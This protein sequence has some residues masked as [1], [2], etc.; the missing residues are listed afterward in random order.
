MKKIVL[1]RNQMHYW[2]HEP[3]LYYYERAD[4]L[5]L[6]T[7]DPITNM[8]YLYTFPDYNV[9]RIKFLGKIYDFVVWGASYSMDTFYYLSNNLVP[10]KWTEDG[11][12]IDKDCTLFNYNYLSD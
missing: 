11:P 9:S 2:Y 7:T 4:V 5:L 12:V 3:Y 10:W 6:V 8:Q 1:T